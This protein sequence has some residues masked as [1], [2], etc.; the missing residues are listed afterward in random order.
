MHGGNYNNFFNVNKP[1][2]TT[3][4]VNGI[5][6]ENGKANS[7]KIFDTLEFTADL[8]NPNTSKICNYFNNPQD[9]PFDYLT[10]WNEYQIGSTSLQYSRGIS[11]L[12]E[13]FRIWRAIIPRNDGTRDRIRN[14]WAF[15]KLSKNDNLGNKQMILHTI[16]VKYFEQ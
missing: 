3:F 13:K 10:I 9:I 4:V 5:G 15:I 12:K 11:N 7:D 14:P 6:S 2:Y 1:Y 16:N 8:I